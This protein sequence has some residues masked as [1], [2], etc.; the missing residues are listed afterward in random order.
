MSSL[1]SLF[2]LLFCVLNLQSILVPFI[3]ILRW[4]FWFRVDI[5]HGPKRSKSVYH[6]ARDSTV[7]SQCLVLQLRV[8]RCIFRTNHPI[9][10]KVFWAHVSRHPCN[11]VL[12]QLYYYV[13]L[14]LIFIPY[15]QGLKQRVLH[16]HCIVWYLIAFILINL[17]EKSC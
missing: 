5:K 3:W 9:Q 6:I 7:W 1:L 14:P 8:K 16:L 10:N 11:M 13:I 12:N 15:Q 2:W 17:I 4:W